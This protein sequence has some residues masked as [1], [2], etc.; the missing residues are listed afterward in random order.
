MQAQQVYYTCYNDLCKP[1][2]I[3]DSEKLPHSKDLKTSQLSFTNLRKKP[4]TFLVVTSW[5]LRQRSHKRCLFRF[6]CKSLVSRLIFNSLSKELRKLLQQNLSKLR[7]VK[8]KISH[9]FFLMLTML[10]L[11]FGCFAAGQHAGDCFLF[12]RCNIY[13]RL[14]NQCMSRLA[15]GFSCL[16]STSEKESLA[17]V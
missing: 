8:T 7:L 16:Y 6:F 12:K 10:N 17:S 9:G 2:K 13:N 1:I 11:L 5:E 14:V 3:F 15:T 4:V